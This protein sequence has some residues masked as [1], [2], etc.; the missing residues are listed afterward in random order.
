MEIEQKMLHSGINDAT[1]MNPEGIEFVLDPATGQPVRAV[2][3]LRLHG[4]AFRQWLRTLPVRPA[5]PPAATPPPAAANPA[6]QL[7]ALGVTPVVI[8][9]LL[10]AAR[11]YLGTPHRIGGADRSGIDC[12]GFTQ[13]AFREVNVNLPRS[14]RDQALIGQ[15]VGLQDVVVGDLVFFANGSNPQVINHVAM[16][17]GRTG[18]DLRGIRFVHASSSR[19]VIEENLLATDYWVRSVRHARRVWGASR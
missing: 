8:D 17:I 12:S 14:S 15:P 13:A 2:V 3:D 5:T 9:T 1:N 10:L 11:S 7:R 18:P 6:E 16:V 4:E 19:G